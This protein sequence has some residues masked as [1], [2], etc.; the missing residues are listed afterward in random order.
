MKRGWIVLL[1][2]VVFTGIS[3]AP[4]QGFDQPLLNFGLTNVLDGAVPGPGTYFFEYVQIYQS[5]EFKDHDGKNIS[6]DPRNGFVLSMN[7]VAHISKTTVLGGNL[8]IDFLLP[9]GSLTASGTFGSGGPPISANPGPVGDV[10]IGPFIQWFPHK[11]LGRPF[12]HRFELD[13]F[14]P[15]G[16]YDKKY[17]IN[18]GSNLWSIEPY[19][20]FTWFLTPQLST[21]WRIHYTYN[22]TNDD[23]WEVLQGMGITEVQPGQ[24]FHFNYSLEYEVVK[25]LRLAAVG[26]YLKQLT[27]TEFNGDN[28]PDRKEQVFAIGPAIH[29]I[30]KNGFVFALKTAIES[31]VENRPQGSRTTFRMI[32]KF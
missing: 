19:Y 32:Y 17:T 31:S 30:T 15:T 3:G 24:V 13:I 12:L 23:P 20:A 22:T 25:N 5:D 18:P 11:L 16:H 14:V 26:Y 2:A 21:S 29:W 8:G 1:V 7:Q 6:G 10:I 9:I 27:D 4:A 28:V